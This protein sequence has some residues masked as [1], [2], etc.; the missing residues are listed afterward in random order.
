MSKRC[1]IQILSYN[2]PKYLKQTLDSLMSVIS[3]DDVICVVEQSDKDNK[4]ERCLNI[5]KQYSNLHVIPLFKNFGQRGATNIVYESGF[6][7]DFKYVMLSD[8]D[9]I[10]HEDIGVYF[11]ILD[12]DPNIWVS[13]GYVSPEHDIENKNGFWLLKSTCRAG[14]MVMRNSDFMSVMPLDV[15]VGECAWFAGLD[16]SL[17]HWGINTPGMKRSGIIACYPGGVEHVGR[18]STWQGTYDDEI[19][20]TELRELRNMNLYDAVKKY[21]PRHTYQTGKYWYEKL[22]DDEFKTTTVSSISKTISKD[23]SLGDDLFDIKIP[24][25]ED[26]KQQSNTIAF[27]YIWPSYG[28]A[29][30]EESIAAVLPYVRAYVIV[31][32]KYSYIGNECDAEALNYVLDICNK[33]DKVIVIYRE[34]NIDPDAANDNIRTY[35]IRMQ[36]IAKVNA[37]DYIWMVQSDEVYDDSMCRQL[38]RLINTGEFVH[39]GGYIFQPLCY[40]DNPHWVVD[41]PEDFNRITLISSDNHYDDPKEKYD[42]IQFHHMSYVMR[43]D[44]LQNKLNNWGHR[45]NIGGDNKIRFGN[46]L[47]LMKTNKSIQDFHPVD[48]SLYHRLKFVDEPINRRL[49]MAWCKHLFEYKNEYNNYASEYDS[50]KCDFPENPKDMYTLPQAVRTCLSSVVAQFLPSGGNLLEIGSWNGVNIS[51]LSRVSDMNFTGIDNYFHPDPLFGQ[52]GDSFFVYVMA[53]KRFMRENIISKVQLYNGWP[54]KLISILP[55]DSLDAVFINPGIREE[56]IVKCIIESWPKVRHDGFYIGQ[57]SKRDQVKELLNTYIQKSISV[58]CPWG[59][60]QFQFSEIYYDLLTDI[61]SEFNKS[62][63][64]QLGFWIAR[65]KKI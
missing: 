35:F 47:N 57:Y 54:K 64:D 45:D 27:N 40:V 60:T 62:F 21:P 3:N 37:V 55:N 17:T 49:F 15:N 51:M 9:N 29:F 22:S 34:N 6:F 32:N 4:Q 11:D 31:V 56:T 30:L 58:D 1:A 65:V 50:L 33:Y 13:T 19:P 14:H 7:N 28:L 63:G 10:F 2:R 38:T 18:N 59:T 46:L 39:N 36:E 12:S 43:K 5:C 41:P 23:T 8:H 16:W 61:E 26:Q 52:Y 48:P 25:I 42:A 53:L 24:H 20:L 44:E